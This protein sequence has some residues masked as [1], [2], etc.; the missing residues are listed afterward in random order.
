MEQTLSILVEGTKFQEQI[1]SQAMHKEASADFVLQLDVSELTDKGIYNHKGQLICPNRY[2]PAFR[3]KVSEFV[4]KFQTQPG[5]SPDSNLRVTF[6]DKIPKDLPKEDIITRIFELADEQDKPLQLLD[7]E[8]HSDDSGRQAAKKALESGRVKTLALENVDN[9]YQ[10][11][12][13]DWINDEPSALMPEKLRRFI[14]D[15]DLKVGNQSNNGTF[16]EILNVAK[17]KQV[18]VILIDSSALKVSQDF[19]DEGLNDRGNNMN[20]VATEVI[21]HYRT[22]YPDSY[23]MDRLLILAGSAHITNVYNSS[24]QVVSVGLNRPFPSSISVSYSG[25]KSFQGGGN[26]KYDQRNSWNS[27]DPLTGKQSQYMIRPDILVTSAPQRTIE[28][29]QFSKTNNDNAEEY[30]EIDSYDPHRSSSKHADAL[31]KDFLKRN[32]YTADDMNTRTEELLRSKV[33]GSEKKTYL[34]AAQRLHRSVSKKSFFFSRKQEKIKKIAIRD[35]ILRTLN[36]IIE[37][38]QHLQPEMLH[39]ESNTNMITPKN[40]QN[41]YANDYKR[42]RVTT[43]KDSSSSPLKTPGLSVEHLI[44]KNVQDRIKAFSKATFKLLNNNGKTSKWIPDLKTLKQN[45]DGNYDLT[46]VHK[47]TSETVNTT[48][49]DKT[50]EQTKHIIEKYSKTLISD[51]TRHRNSR[52]SALKTPTTGFFIMAYELFHGTTLDFQKSDI[53][54]Q[55]KSSERSGPRR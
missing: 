38:Q 16:E 10:K 13:H 46:L 45:P 28:E 1:L 49:P 53:K 55:N 36:G 24:N 2:D 19:P 29:P 51:S 11:L 8:S 31:I 23:D 26:F 34:D 4:S 25:P 40:D 52:E 43:S 50:F 33:K 22:N 6:H 21:N 5:P 7:G 18:Q 27:E 9:K 3:N 37:K 20:F 12:L 30:T 47:D 54:Y 14:Q 32:S 48:T 35:E 42:D 17:K 15:L 39:V 44:K 41:Q